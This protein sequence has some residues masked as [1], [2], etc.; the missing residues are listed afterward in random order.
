MAPFGGWDMPI[1][2][3]SI[4]EEHQTVRSAAGAFDVSHMGRLHFRGEAGAQV[5]ERMTTIHV[6]A[7]T[8]GRAKYGFVLNRHAGI[9][10]DVILYTL[11]D[12]EWMLVVNASNRRN[13]LR[14]LRQHRANPACFV[15]ETETTG[16][17]AL[18]GPTAREVFAKAVP[19]TMVPE[20]SMRAAAEGDLLLLTT[21]YTGEDGLE[22]IA[23]AEQIGPL[24]DAMLAAGAKPIG[25]GARD[26]LRLEMGYPLHGHEISRER[27]PW[28][29]G[30]G[31]GVD[32]RNETSHG[33]DRLLALRE[34]QSTELAALVCTGKGIPRAGNVVLV[35]GAERGHVTSGT[36]S[37]SLQ[38]GI[39][40]AYLCESCR[41]E[42]SSV[43]IAPDSASRRKVEAVVTRL[44]F[45]AEGSRRPSG[46]G[47]KA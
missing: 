33:R 24:W 18:Q 29:A 40:L 36:F 5:L 37:P 9:V 3:G 4:A 39:A 19:G 30:L 23:P 12:D 46:P 2:Y 41:A 25:L 1:T 16:M 15:D 45:Y 27:S 11:A 43:E 8:P 6:P 28:Q 14:K 38:K 26:T 22:V 17:I 13:V 34:E 32:L 44:P 20:Y 7:V 47:R 21:G 35:D 42:G 31:W 10:D